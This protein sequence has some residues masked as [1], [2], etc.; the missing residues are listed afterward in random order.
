MFLLVK[1]CS[2]LSN[3]CDWLKFGEEYKSFFAGTDGCSTVSRIGS[4]W[5]VTHRT[6][7]RSGTPGCTTWPTKRPSLNLPQIGNFTW[8]IAQTCLLYSTSGTLLPPLL[9]PR[10]NHGPQCNPRK[11][12]DQDNAYEF[13]LRTFPLLRG[14]WFDRN[15]SRNG[16]FVDIKRPI[17]S[18]DH[19]MDLKCCAYVAN[20]PKWKIGYHIR[21]R[22]KK[23]YL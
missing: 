13:L 10:L 8:N 12:N 18:F 1:D 14:T 15:V 3:C 22:R 20:V 2:L 17:I 9:N 23:F 5:R 6:Y 21:T 7:R 19:S 16:D 4:F 11:S